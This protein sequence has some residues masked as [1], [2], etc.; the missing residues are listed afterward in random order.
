MFWP[1]VG[2]RYLELFGQVVSA[3]AQAPERVRRIG[4]ATPSAKVRP[5]K[6][7]RGGV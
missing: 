2:Q 7:M 5:V 3:K 6:L 4:F 1:N